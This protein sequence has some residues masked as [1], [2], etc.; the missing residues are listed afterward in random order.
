[1]LYVQG[2]REGQKN[3]WCLFKAWPIVGAS[4]RRKEEKKEREGRIDSDKKDHRSDSTVGLV[5]NHNPLSLISPSA[6]PG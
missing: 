5:I 4:H 1:M 2:A 6:T 3:P